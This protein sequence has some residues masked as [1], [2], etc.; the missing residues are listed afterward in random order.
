MSALVKVLVLIDWLRHDGERRQPG[1]EIEVDGHAADLLE[2]Q[3]AVE[4]FTPGKAR[5]VEQG[6]KADGDA[7]ASESDTGQRGSDVEPEVDADGKVRVNHATAETLRSVRGI[8]AQLADA[9]VA[10]RRKEGPFEK[11]DDLVGL[12]G[13]GPRNI[14]AL[15]DQLTCT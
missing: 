7:D 13:I 5:K 8:G 3:G 10:R 2:A 6:A 1:D 12:P 4:R 9:I 14:Q 11:V 15:A